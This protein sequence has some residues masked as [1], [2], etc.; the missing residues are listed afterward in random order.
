[1]V[2]DDRMKRA[3]AMRYESRDEGY[4]AATGRIKWLAGV[5]PQMTALQ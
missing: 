5:S 2:T 1:M 3:G 4:T